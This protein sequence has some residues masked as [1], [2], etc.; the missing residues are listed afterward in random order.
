VDLRYQREAYTDAR[1][2]SLDRIR[3]SRIT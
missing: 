3:H 1:T 2:I